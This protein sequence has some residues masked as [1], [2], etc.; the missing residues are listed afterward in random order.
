[1]KNKILII[2]SEGF[3]GKSISQYFLTLGHIVFTA[4]IVNLSKSNYLF[5]KSDISN[6]PNLFKHKNFDICIN[7][8]GLANVSNSF[9]ESNQDFVANVFN[10][11][12]IL[13]AIKLFNKNCKFINLSSAAVYGNP[14]S[15]PISELDDLNPI[16]PYGY[17]KLMSEVLCCEYNKVFDIQTISLRIFSVYGPGSRKQLFWDIYKKIEKSSNGTIE[18]IGNG[19]ESRDF[20]FIDDLLEAVSCIIENSTFDGGAI[21][22]ASGEETLIKNAIYTFVNLLQPSIKIIFD[23][24]VRNGD[25]SNWQA[26]ISLL[27]SFGFK[28]KYNLEF[29]LNKYVTWLKQQ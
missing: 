1:M 21:N 8:S 18:I 3:I 16:S 5:L 12:I 7:A 22:V 25:P 10:V 26:D 9:D 19:D 13:E 29:G 23:N 20:I 2:G 15:Y 17:H 24:K 28:H 6:L 14:K 11:H 4:D 27:E